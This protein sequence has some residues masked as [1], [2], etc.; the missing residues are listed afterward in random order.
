ML[1]ATTSRG[2]LSRRIPRLPPGARSADAV[3]RQEPCA[4]GAGLEA[5]RLAVDARGGGDAAR[6]GDN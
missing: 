2:K 6:L 5:A 1:S 3:G 4:A